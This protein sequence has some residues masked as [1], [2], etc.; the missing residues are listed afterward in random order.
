MTTIISQT[1]NIQSIAANATE[2]RHGF[3]PAAGEWKL[4]EALFV[5]STTSAANG[6]NY[7]TI[8]LLAGTGGTSLATL[9]SASVAFTKGTGRVFTLSGGTALEFTGGA[10]T[11]CVEIAITQA[12]SGAVVDGSVI[13]TWR[14]LA[15]DS[16]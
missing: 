2:E 1:I 10:G 16:A 12:A 8:S 3:P 4:E 14:K 6:T 11:D 5:P 7:A 15:R 13:L 9:T